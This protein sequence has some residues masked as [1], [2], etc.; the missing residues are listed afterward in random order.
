MITAFLL[1]WIE[2]FFVLLLIIIIKNIKEKKNLDLSLNFNYIILF[3]AVL[4]LFIF[5]YM[6]FNGITMCQLSK[7]IYC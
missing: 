5:S 3:F 6:S 1:T 4:K 2:L 7:Q